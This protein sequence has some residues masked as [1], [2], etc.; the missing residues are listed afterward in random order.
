M[1]TSSSTLFTALLAGFVFPFQAGINSQLRL[2][3][4]H[5]ILAALVSF[6]IGTSL[7]L[8]YPLILGVPLPAWASLREVPW[9][10]WIGGVLG[11]FTVTSTILLAPRLGAVVL[12][13]T[14]VT[15]QMIASIILDHYGLVG[16]RTHPVNP[17]RLVGVVLVKWRALAAM[18]PLSELRP[19]QPPA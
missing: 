7:L 1:R 8:M 15:G 17:W 9:G 19:E 18:P 11:A 13:A 12:I 6:L 3:L 5:P 16:F 2:W 10:A 14:V 4:G